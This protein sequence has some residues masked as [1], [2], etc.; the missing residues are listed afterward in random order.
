VNGAVIKGFCDLVK[1]GFGRDPPADAFECGFDPLAIFL[2]VRDIDVLAVAFPIVDTSL[3]ILI[4]H[5]HPE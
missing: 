5:V 2:R 4:F 1:H 3:A